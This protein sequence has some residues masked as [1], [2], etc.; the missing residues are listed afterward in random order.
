MTLHRSTLKPFWASLGLIFSVALLALSMPRF[1]SS[2]YSLYPETLLKQT[3]TIKDAFY[4][5][6]INELDTAISWHN[7]PLYWQNKALCY[8]K[9]YYSTTTT[10][11]QK[12]DALKLGQSALEQGLSLSP[13]DPFAWYR[14]ASARDLANADIKQIQSAY[15]LSLYSGRV[16]PELLSPRIKFGLNHSKSFDFEANELWLKQIPVLFQ[17]QSTELVNLA[18]TTPALKTFIFAVFLFEH[19]KLMQFNK[20]FESTYQKILKSQK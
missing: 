12:S 17:L 11:E 2:L 18:I 4:Y 20:A 9:L 16:E 15:K 1:I 14:L 8:L 6:A 5:N 10:P 13:I 19:E 7:D 3:K